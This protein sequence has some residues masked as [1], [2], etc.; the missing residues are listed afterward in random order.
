MSGY[1]QD[2]ENSRRTLRG[3]VAGAGDAEAAARGGNP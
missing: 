2:I 3:G 1:L